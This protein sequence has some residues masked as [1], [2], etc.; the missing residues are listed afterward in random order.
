MYG[1]NWTNYDNEY[2]GASAPGTS[3]DG[4]TE[5]RPENYTIKIWKRTA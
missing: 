1:E 2:T 5:A 3:S 4:G